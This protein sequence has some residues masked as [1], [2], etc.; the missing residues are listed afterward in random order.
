MDT[1]KIVRDSF[2]SLKERNM[3]LSRENP[4][5]IF[6]R[7]FAHDEEVLLHYHNTLEINFS[8]NMS[9]KVTVGSTTLDLSSNEIIVLS[10]DCLHSYQIRKSSGYMIILHISLSELENY[11]RLDNL[12]SVLHLNPR[13]LPLTAP[14]YEKLTSLLHEIEM[15]EQPIYS[16]PTILKVFEILGSSVDGDGGANIQ[17]LQ[18]DSIKHIVDYTEDNYSE[19]F[20]LDEVSSRFGYTRSYFC[21][22]FKKRTSFRY[23]DYLTHVRIEHAK[24]K[25]MQGKGVSQTGYECGFDDTSYF[26]RVFKVHTG[27]T[28]GGYGKLKL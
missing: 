5:H 4:I 20:T 26:I 16:L 11:F 12:F 24:E 19:S 8:C 23:W 3:W 15:Q 6:R 14:G 13:Q 27:V 18:D 17:N 28:P 9:G 7:H 1:E 21:R 2:G 22:F 10:P 25:L